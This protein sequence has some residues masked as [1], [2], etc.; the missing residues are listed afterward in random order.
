MAPGAGI[1]RGGLSFLGMKSQEGP[2]PPAATSVSEAADVARRVVRGAH[3]PRSG[4]SLR[5]SRP[6]LTA[7]PLRFAILA[8]LA[9]RARLSG[10]GHPSRNHPDSA[11]THGRSDLNARPGCT[12]PRTFMHRRQRHPIRKPEAP[13][14]GMRM[15]GST[16]PR[17]RHNVLLQTLPVA[18]VGGAHAPSPDD[19]FG[20]PG[21]RSRPVRGATPSWLGWLP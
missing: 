7:C 10:H 20:L 21:L 13:A 8:S 3:T 15:A 6:S 1:D 12:S 17:H 18:W 9:P 5:P 14:T 16:A 19:R 11:G 4:R 2:F